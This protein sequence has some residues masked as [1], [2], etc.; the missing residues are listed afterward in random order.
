MKRI[1][2]VLGAKVMQTA[3]GQIIPGPA[4]ARRLDAAA[5]PAA[6]YSIIVVTGGPRN[7][8]PSEADVSAQVLTA[9]GVKASKL[10]IENQSRTTFENIVMVQDLLIK[11]GYIPSE[12][13]LLSDRHHLPRAWVIA[14]LL[15]LRVTLRPAHAPNLSWPKWAIAVLR[16]L[17]A[18]PL[19]VIRALKHRTQRSRWSD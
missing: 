15:G 12:L 18:V 11:A 17:A 6:N 5:Q 4:L 8:L 14:R 9:A 10:L 13:T 3:E 16:E 7:G 2:V 1:L 19:S